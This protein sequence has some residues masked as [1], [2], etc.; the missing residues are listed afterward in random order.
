MIIPIDMG[1]VFRS[2]SPPVEDSQA[3]QALLELMVCLD[4]Q[5]LRRHG[6]QVPRLYESGIRYGRTNEWLPYWVLLETRVGDCKSLA[7]ARCAELREQGM[8][9]AMQHRWVRRRDGGKDFHI[10][11]EIQDESGTPT[12]YE[13]PSKRCGMVDE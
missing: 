4:R 9:V 5:F 10:L 7:T 8:R 3:L 11:I 2:G 6:Q 1:Y 13:D 12:G